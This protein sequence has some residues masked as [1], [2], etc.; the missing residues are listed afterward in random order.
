MPLGIVGVN[1]KARAV[2][3]TG[4]LIAE[5]MTLPSVPD[6]LLTRVPAW[7]A[8]PLDDHR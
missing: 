3:S 5:T 1:Q 8:P 6:S 2:H 7:G 4:R